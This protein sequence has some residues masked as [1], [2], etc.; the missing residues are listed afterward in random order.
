MYFSP[1][2]SDPTY[3]LQ[4]TKKLCQVVIENREQRIP[5]PVKEEVT[6][7][8]PELHDLM[9]SIHTHHL[10]EDDVILIKGLQQHSETAADELQ[11]SSEGV[12]CLSPST[13][14]S[15]S[16]MFT[17]LRKYTMGF[18]HAIHAISKN[19]AD[20]SIQSTPKPE[21]IPTAGVS[22]PD[23]LYTQEINLP[24]PED[25][26]CL[27]DVPDLAVDVPPRLTSELQYHQHSLQSI[28]GSV[29][30]A[31]DYPPEGIHSSC[32]ATDMDVET[33]H[34]LLPPTGSQFLEKLS[35]FAGWLSNEILSAE[36]KDSVHQGSD[37]TFL[38]LKQ[39]EIGTS[40]EGQSSSEMFSHDIIPDSHLNQTF[41]NAEESLMSSQDE[42]MASKS[43]E[44]E[45]NHEV[46]ECG[47]ENVSVRD[48]AN[49][50]SR[51]ASNIIQ[52][53]FQEIG[54]GRETPLVDYVSNTTNTSSS[55]KPFAIM[56]PVIENFALGL[57][58]DIISDSTKRVSS[59]W[60]VI[61]RYGEAL[62][63]ESKNSHLAHLEQDTPLDLS[64]MQWSP[65]HI[66]THEHNHLARTAPRSLCAELLA[67]EQV[68]GL[69]KGTQWSFVET[70]SERERHLSAS[71]KEQADDQ[72][73]ENLV[74]D[75]F[76]LTKGGSLDYPNAPPPTPLKPQLAGSQRSF[77]RKL[78][79]G[80]AKEFLPS[81][82]PPTPKETI[83]FCLSSEGSEEKAEFMRKLL[84]SLSQEFR[85]GASEVP[86][87]EKLQNV[88]Q[89]CPSSAGEVIEGLRTDE[90]KV[91]DYFS[92]LV[93]NIV[94][95][96]AQVI[97]GITREPIEPKGHNE[98][99]CHDVA[100]SSD[101]QMNS[102]NWEKPNPHPSD[103]VLLETEKIPSG[104][105]GHKHR[106]SFPLL[107]ESKFCEYTDRLTQEIISS[108]FSFLNQIESLEYGEH[109]GE[110][111]G[112]GHKDCRHSC[113]IRQL[114]S[115][116]EDLG[117]RV[118]QSALQVYKT[119]YQLQPASTMNLLQDKVHP[120]PATELLQ[121][122][123]T[124]TSNV[125]EIFLTGDNEEQQFIRPSLETMKPVAR[126]Q[127]VDLDI[128][129]ECKQMAK[130]Q[131]SRNGIRN[132][133]SPHEETYDKGG[134]YAS[135]FSPCPYKQP[136]VKGKAEEL[137]GGNISNF[138]HAGTK[139]GLH[140]QTKEGSRQHKDLD[141]FPDLDSEPI[142][143]DE[144]KSSILKLSEVIMK[145]PDCKKLHKTYAE[146]LAETILNSSLTEVYR[147]CSSGEEVLPH[148]LKTEESHRNALSVSSSS[149]EDSLEVQQ[150]I[151]TEQSCKGK[152]ELPFI[153]NTKF[154]GLNI[155]EYPGYSS[156]EQPQENANESIVAL[157]QCSKE[158][159]SFEEMEYCNL[160]APKTIE[161]FLVNFNSASTTVDAQI[162]AML[163]WASA[164]QLNVS[165]IHIN[166][167]SEDFAQFPTL[168]TLA[169]ERGMDSGRPPLCC[170]NFL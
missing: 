154:Q 150:K 16:S 127:A 50:A 97:C 3:W 103:G 54:Y 20:I 83:N 108:V 164:S 145:D 59:E 21:C 43:T 29:Q 10:K 11:S 47:S 93:S 55:G 44:W 62:E 131:G 39:P 63:G 6:T 148:F 152:E 163:Q 68:E 101:C 5:V 113:Y 71:H 133:A 111:K 56:H 155:I 15:G 36:N 170:A 143:N 121:N 116:S 153:L 147:Q 46:S 123:D 2:M 122:T 112:N 98:Q 57:T 120:V 151:Q 72:D 105:N 137:A 74:Y 4:S 60:K 168:F 128:D 28:S 157:K 58:Q 139:M 99:R 136:V 167:S 53:S 130:T 119:Q 32:D 67:S 7:T 76:G 13:H 82:P 14:A 31:T 169:E 149:G 18:Q 85:A 37:P 161:L 19:V 95:S 78:K 138:V 132:I 146:S 125:E 80:L 25:E 102:Q 135:F 61:S 126:S 88:P 86:E 40:S 27:H 144:K 134:N 70:F 8:Y 45:R 115:M 118:V 12:M 114:N 48:I 87:D 66:G 26:P 96:A 30:P 69:T 49:M 89:E 79:G 77:T 65:S 24:P 104:N 94:F 41:A 100:F 52:M 159:E 35:T 38:H 129:P 142:I 64:E 162:Q 33:S 51:E 109:E 84:R 158:L 90:K 91:Q 166:N 42:L 160:L 81:P 140:E 92:D 117:K 73:D 107:T 9:E 156:T 17:S 22:P 124:A 1:Q 106:A 110:R 165:K 75:K 23:I 141:A 34:N